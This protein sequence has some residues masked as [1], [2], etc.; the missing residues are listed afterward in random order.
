MT[1]P[2]H[3]LRAYTIIETLIAMSLTALTI[4]LILTSIRLI[5]AHQRQFRRKMDV[6]TEYMRLHNALQKDT[7]H[8]E[9]IG[10]V[11][12]AITFMRDGKFI[13]YHRLDTLYIRQERGLTDTFHIR[14]DSIDSWFLAQ[15]LTDST[16]P[17]D[18]ATLFLH[19][20]GNLHSISISKR[21][22]AAMTMR[23]TAIRDE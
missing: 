1:R 9:N 7:H 15:R 4:G 21:Y 23:L 22:D 19:I 3:T 18:E 20:D 17:L 14:T 8:A 13:R 16:G 5:D 12:H 10:I 11:D 6:Y 2:H